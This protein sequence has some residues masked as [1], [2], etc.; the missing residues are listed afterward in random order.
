MALK[1]IDKYEA[2]RRGFYGGAI[3]FFDFDGNYNH[4]ILIRSFLS[5]NNKLY[6]Q[7]GAGIVASSDEESELQETY[8]K[9]GAL[10]KALELA[11]NL[12]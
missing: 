4:A 12:R 8:N 9:L 11:E 7:A 10:Q 5:K 6:Y 2:T 3:G 1:L